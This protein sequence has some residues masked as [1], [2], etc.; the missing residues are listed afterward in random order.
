MTTDTQSCPDCGEQK[1]FVSRER[2]EVICRE[3]SYVIDDAMIDFGRERFLDN[4][5]MEKNSRTGAPFDPTVTN[6]LMTQVGNHADVS[7]LSGNIRYMVKRIRKKNAWTSS[8]IE[9]NLNRSLPHLKMI[10]SYIKVPDNI[11]KESARIYRSAVEKGLTKARSCDGVIVAS[12]YIACR[13]FGFP[14]TI[15][16]ISEASKLNKKVVGKYYK[17]VLRE[18]GMKME[19]SN[20]LDHIARYASLLGLSAKVQSKAAEIADKA[21]KKDITSGVSPV[22]IAATSL[23]LAS[24]LHGEKRTQK[25]VTDMTQITEVTLRTRCK[26]FIETL[27]LKVKVR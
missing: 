25:A 21:Q 3:C 7:K 15:K 5:D 23:Y 2:G 14:A 4:E 6:N 22:T 11:E 12:V 8:S 20:P 10:C 26:D 9:N 16:D 1:F 18:L 19:P 17:L 24:L 13:L 27:K